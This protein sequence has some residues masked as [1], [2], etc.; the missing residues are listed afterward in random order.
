MG[1]ERGG[2]AKP[3]GPQTAEETCPRVGPGEVLPCKLCGCTF[4]GQRIHSA[5]YRGSVHK[6][7]HLVAEAMGFPLAEVV[8]HHIEEMAKVDHV[9]AGAE[10]DPLNVARRPPKPKREVDDDGQVGLF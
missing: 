6:G 4:I 3:A 2:K 7:C 8:L 1:R 10:P 5:R 9:I